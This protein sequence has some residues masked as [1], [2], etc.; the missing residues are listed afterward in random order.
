MKKILAV[1]VE[2]LKSK[3]IGAVDL[4]IEVRNMVMD[5]M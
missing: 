3:K 1:F 5:Y 4:S 2:W